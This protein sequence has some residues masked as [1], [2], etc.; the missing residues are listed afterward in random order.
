MKHI[1]TLVAAIA[2][3]SGLAACDRTRIVSF[4]PEGE[5]IFD[6]SG[7]YAF[8]MNIGTDLR[9]GGL[10]LD[11]DEFIRGMQDAMRDEARYSMDEAFGIFQTALMTHMERRNEAAR[12]RETDFLDANAVLPGIT[13][14][15]SGLQFAV[16]EMGGGDMPGPFDTVRVHYEGRLTDGTV[17]DSSFERGIPAEFPLFG[18]IPGWTEG[19]QL[20]P[21]GSTFR[22]YIPSRLGYGSHGAGPDIPPYSALIFDVELLAILSDEE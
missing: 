14:T 20:M 7:S 2:L 6:G 12:Q 11:M 9:M 1:V 15:E 5:E 10:F 17:F 19:L 3:A 13:V 4:A 18:V 21:V 22:F 16:V 8:G